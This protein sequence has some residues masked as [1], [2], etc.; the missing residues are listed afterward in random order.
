[1]NANERR[2]TAPP[3]DNVIDFLD[4]KRIGL[5]CKSNPFP[6]EK[7]NHVVTRRRCRSTFVRIHRFILHL[8]SN[9]DLVHIMLL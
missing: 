8:S 1:M 4:R 5:T 6:V 2:S 7:I 9:Q 3:G